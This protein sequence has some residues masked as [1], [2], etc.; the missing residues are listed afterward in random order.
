MITVAIIVG[1]VAFT[2]VGSTAVALFHVRQQDR[3]RR[4]ESAGSAQ[5]YEGLA[6]AY[7]RR[8]LQLQSRG[9]HS[10]AQALRERADQ[11]RAEARQAPW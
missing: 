7:E 2:V 4:S 1:A 10:S 6:L 9:C 3:A 8:A 5:V 11:L